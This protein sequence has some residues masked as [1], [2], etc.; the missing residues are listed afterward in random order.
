ML[1]F[2]GRCTACTTH[3]RTCSG[4]W[5]LHW[6]LTDLGF[7]KPMAIGVLCHCG[8]W[9]QGFGTVAGLV[10]GRGQSGGQSGDRQGSLVKMWPFEDVAPATQCRR[11]G[12][13]GVQ[14]CAHILS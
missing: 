8:E 6:G 11:S 14:R 13:L 4:D 12:L 1:P 3:F 10:P 7:E 9:S 5:D 2:W